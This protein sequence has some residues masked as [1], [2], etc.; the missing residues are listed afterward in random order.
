MTTKRD[1]PW[2]SH[3]EALRAQLS[4]LRRMEQSNAVYREMCQ[5]VNEKKAPKPSG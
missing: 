1:V 4:K 3:V 2:P 5:K